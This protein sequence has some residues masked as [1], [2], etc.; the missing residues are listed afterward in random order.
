[1][2]KNTPSLRSP[3]SWRAGFSPIETLGALGVVGMLSVT[4]LPRIFTAINDSRINGAAQSYMMVK[5]AALRYLDQRAFDHPAADPTELTAETEAAAHWDAAVL[6]PAGFLDQ[7]FSTKISQRARLAVTVCPVAA[8]QPTAANSAYNF[9]GFT[10]TANATLDGKI[11]V[12]AILE[13]VSRDDA[14]ELNRRIDGEEPAV[15]ETAPGTDF[16]GRVKYDFSTNRVA[17]VR[18]YVTHR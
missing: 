11:V 18:I 13:G 16:G 3:R 10:P 17:N 8:C 1:M 7:S 14:R 9:S 6:R 5:T 12:E 2:K 4:L 15:G